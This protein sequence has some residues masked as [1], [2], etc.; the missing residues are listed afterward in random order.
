MDIPMPWKKTDVPMERARFIAE[1][2]EG[3]WSMTDLCTAFGISRNTGHR[4]IARYK[5]EGSR[6]LEDRSRAPLTRPNRV[7]AR[8]EKE[9]LRVRARFQTWGS[10]KILTW[11]AR[12]A[13]D[14]PLPARSTVDEMLKRAGYVRPRKRL[15]R[16]SPSSRPLTEPTAPNRVWCTDFK[17]H[18]RL[19]NGDRCHPLTANDSCSRFVLICKALAHPR[20]EDV[21]ACFERAFR[22]YGLPDV[23]RSDNGTPFASRG[24]GGLTR[25]S[26]WWLRLG[27]L[28][29]RIEPGKPQQNGRLER[30][31]LT[32]QQEA[33]D[34]PKSN[35]V[36]QQRAFSKHRRD[37]NEERPHEALGMRTPA[38]VYHRSK[39]SYP[40]KL[41]DFEYPWDFEQRM[42]RT[43]GSFKW[44]GK[45]IFV[46]EALRGEHIGLRMVGDGAWSIFLGPLELGRF[47]E[48]SG[49]V[50][51]HP[52]DSRGP[53]A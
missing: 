44:R 48:Y 19:G 53:K 42:V 32:L 28:P 39:R 22:E 20:L 2:E 9:I 51:P 29:E 24:I 16:A 11:L 38:E 49:T 47:H 43:R 26:V 17:G 7:P 3:C 23:I 34:P 14:L 31:H 41:P 13:P 5:R 12:R 30:Y 45:S 10:K 25:L 40:A 33:A 21:Q 35:P 8:V 18:F 1:Y 15:R 27:I 37:F 4:L 6:A 36:G 46:S 50:V 52:R